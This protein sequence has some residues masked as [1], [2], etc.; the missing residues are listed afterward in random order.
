MCDVIIKLGTINVFLFNSFIS[1][2][3]FYLNSLDRSFPTE[4][5]S[6]FLLFFFLRMFYRNSFIFY[7]NSVNPDQTP[8][9]A[10]SDQSI[11]F[12]MSLLSDTSHKWVRLQLHFYVCFKSAGIVFNQKSI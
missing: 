5:T 9:S 11:L 1:S 10:A 6:V 7:V 3:F 4:G 12:A 2:R 8:H